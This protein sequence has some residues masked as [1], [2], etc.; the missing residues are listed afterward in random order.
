LQQYFEQQAT[1][2]STLPDCPVEV[3]RGP[4]GLIVSRE[5]VHDKGPPG[6]YGRE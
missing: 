5:R 4:F 6:F 3:T 1:S 2:W